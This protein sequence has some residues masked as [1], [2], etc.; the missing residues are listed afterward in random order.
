MPK[1][2]IDDALE[3]AYESDD[4]TD[5]W[6]KPE[7]VVLQHGNAH[8]SQWFYAW[9]PTLARHYRVIRPSLRGFG[10]STLAPPNYRWSLEGFVSDLERFL[11]ALG[12]DRV[13]Y[14]GES[15]G[16]IIGWGLAYY[17]PERLK[18]L[19]ICTIPAKMKDLPFLKEHR[20]VEILQQEG[21]TAFFAPFTSGRLGKAGDPAHAEWLIEEAKKVPAESIMG[22]FQAWADL[23]LE[24]YLPKIQVPTLLLIGQ[25][26]TEILTVQDYERIRDLM[27]QAKLATFP[28]IDGLVQFAAPE[29]CAEAVLAFIEEQEA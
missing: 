9:V 7:T 21:K 24:P 3:I 1:V 17:H 29:R 6:K 8:S 16:G 10:G 14:V 4:F 28:G 13:H 5:P 26:H 22:V 15:S 27:P 19:T 20:Q 12:L 25:E 2:R 18:T 11:D 23:D